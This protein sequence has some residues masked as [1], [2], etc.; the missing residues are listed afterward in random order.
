MHQ[1]RLAEGVVEGHPLVEGLQ[2]FL[3]REKIDPHWIQ[4]LKSRVHF[5]YPKTL[6]I[7]LFAEAPTELKLR[8]ALDP[9]R[10]GGALNRWIKQRGEFR[11]IVFD[12]R[13][14]RI[15]DIDLMLAFFKIVSSTLSERFYLHDAQLADVFDR[16]NVDE[17][18]IF[19]S[20][21]AML[22]RLRSAP[23]ASPCTVEMPGTLT[24]DS[25]DK[26]LRRYAPAARLAQA[27]VVI[28][29]MQSVT[30]IDFQALSMLAPTIHSIAHLHGTLA[31][32]SNARRT[33]TRS[34]EEHGTFQIVL[35]YLTE[36]V[37]IA[38]TPPN[39]AGIL[40]ILAFTDQ[41]F[42]EVQRFFDQKV[43]TMFDAFKEWFSEIARLTPEELKHISVSRTEDRISRFKYLF[44]NLQQIIK[45]LAENVA[46]HSHGLG[47]LAMQ[48]DRN[49]GLRIYVGDT[50]IGLAKG[51]RAHYQLPIRSDL[52]A[53]Q[54]AFS[55]G[56]YRDKRRK[57]PGSSFLTGGRGLD[58]VGFILESLGGEVIVRSGTAVAAFQPRSG[59]DATLKR[60]RLYNVLGT[61]VHL[62]IPPRL[63]NL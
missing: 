30:K 41:E 60:S 44:T 50:G 16:R 27:D 4:F 13:G 14:V 22:S 48:L 12:L 59:R 5:A 43:E 39:L 51:I 33:I 53:V 62:F 34:F 63:S 31:S 32:V 18:A 35:P 1:H 9:E 25:F 57:D 20:E 38:T 17:K 55:L 8:H 56:N 6:W 37:G 45:E 36:P 61:H 54:L 11:R 3:R 2:Q 15:L 49:D 52:S 47:Y 10:I 19:D 21:A 46:A 23:N 29:D 28:F 24:L 7:K 42:I 40:P 58:K 26:A